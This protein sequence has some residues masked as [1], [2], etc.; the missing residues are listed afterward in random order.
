MFL[1][2]E[3]DFQFAESLPRHEGWERM[4]DD[5][6]LHIETE[7]DRRW[8]PATSVASETHIIPQKAPTDA[9]APENIPMCM[10][11]IMHYA[12]KAHRYK[13]GDLIWFSWN[14]AQ[15]GHEA[16]FSSRISYGSQFIAYTRDGAR[17][18]KKAIE[19]GSLPCGHWDLVLKKFLSA[20][21]TAVKYCY[22]FPPI[23]HFSVHAS[24]CDPKQYP[25]GR[26]N[27]WR[28]KWVCEGTR[29]AEDKQNRAKYF[30]R[31]NENGRTEWAGA[32]D[33]CIDNDEFLWKTFVAPGLLNQP[34][35]SS[36]LPSGTRSAVPSSAST[37]QD[38]TRPA[39]SSFVDDGSVGLGQSSSSSSSRIRHKRPE[40]TEDYRRKLRQY[41]GHRNRRQFI[42]VLDQACM[43]CA[44]YWVPILEFLFV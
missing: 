7:G 29:Q 22:M 9:F 6:R 11:D 36:D 44:W 41:I 43:V 39:P 33:D 28:K 19:D 23:G 31:F 4:Y 10:R 30:A 15:P 12:T 16:R 5:R 40:D 35:P 21:P 13:Q 20:H 25:E 2:F 18:L 1:L 3:E 14:A 26:P 27:D 42:Q 8:T 17:A 37:Y 32:A 38:M 34:P 24:D